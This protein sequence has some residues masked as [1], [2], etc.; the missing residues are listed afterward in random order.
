MVEGCPLQSSWNRYRSTGELR[1]HQSR[2]S[3]TR[4][5]C[6]CLPTQV[7]HAGCTISEY[8]AMFPQTHDRKNPFFCLAQSIGAASSQPRRFVARWVFSRRL[9]VSRYRKLVHC[10]WVQAGRVATSVMD[11]LSHPQVAPLLRGHSIDG[12]F[13][14]LHGVL[15][16]AFNLHLRWRSPRPHHLSLKISALSRRRSSHCWLSVVYIWSVRMRTTSRSI[17]AIWICHSECRVVRRWLCLGQCA[18]GVRVCLLYTAA[19]HA[20]CARKKSGGGSRRKEMRSTTWMTRR[21][22]NRWGSG[23]IRPF[24]ELPDKVVDVLNDQSS[25]SSSSCPKSMHVCVKNTHS[26]TTHFPRKRS[27]FYHAHSAGL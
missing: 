7:C 15:S 21:D 26:G 2:L 17:I 19:E 25:R 10:K 27:H 3:G 24:G 23:I 11:K 5:V 16:P 13:G 12:S 6:H 4:L 20:L 18:N 9:G 22:S 8:K 14:P 1:K